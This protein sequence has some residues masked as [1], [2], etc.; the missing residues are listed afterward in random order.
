MFNLPGKASSDSTVGVPLLLWCWHR[1]GRNTLSLS[2]L[3]PVGGFLRK[4]GGG[5][6]GGR[7]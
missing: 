3:T 2:F 4:G 6:D 5:S 1:N 7:Y